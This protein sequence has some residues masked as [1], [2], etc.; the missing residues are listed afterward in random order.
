MHNF[1]LE[2]VVSALAYAGVSF[3]REE[4]ER[5]SEDQSG[6][7]KKIGVIINKTDGRQNNFYS[8]CIKELWEIGSLPFLFEIP[9][10]PDLFSL[11]SDITFPFLMLNIVA[12]ELSGLLKDNNITAGVA[13]LKHNGV[14][15][16]PVLGAMLHR[17]VLLKKRSGE[18]FYGVI[19]Y[20][21]D[22]VAQQSSIDCFIAASL[23]LMPKEGDCFSD[24]DDAIRGSKLA[25]SLLNLEGNK[26]SEYSIT[27]IAKGNLGNAVTSWAALGGTVDWLLNLPF[28]AA[29]AGVELLFYDMA[30]I[31][32]DTPMLI[33]SEDDIC[34]KTSEMFL[35]SLFTRGCMEDM[36]TV[37]G[38]WSERFPATC[39]GALEYAQYLPQKPASGIILLKGNVCESVVMREIDVANSILNTFKKELFL[40]ISFNCKEVEGNSNFSD[41]TILYRLASSV[42]KE[43]IIGYISIAAAEWQREIPRWRTLE[44]IPL[45]KELLSIQVLRILLVIYGDGH[46]MSGLPVRNKHITNTDLFPLLKPVI[47]TLT[48][49]IWGGGEGGL[50]LASPEA[51][52]LLPG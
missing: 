41:E 22:K 48:D 47:L 5:R 45:L 31:S 44:L 4:L 13:L 2:R 24:L 52:L 30:A 29:V 27:E 7:V 12:V 10:E 36:A 46:L 16:A 8:A 17:A 39:Q 49:G 51:F 37:N 3:S 23:G 34:G 11:S 1:S 19:G 50:I 25:V 21:N 14:G 43:D 15:L 33:S 6:A 20:W 38:L 18:D 26:K 32:K 35:R 40:V 28:V 9:D 42:A